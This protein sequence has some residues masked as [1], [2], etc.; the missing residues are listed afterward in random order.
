MSELTDPIFILGSHKSGSSLLRSLLDGHPDLYA[1]PTEAHFFQ[2]SG[3]WVD[4]RLRYAFPKEMNRQELIESFVS[5]IE[6]KNRHVNPYADSMLKGKFN[7]KL[8]KS[9]LEKAN[10]ESSAQLFEAYTSAIYLS[11]EGTSLPEGIRIVEKS[12][13]NAEFAIFLK[14]MMPSCRFIHIVRNPY[15]TLTA[16]RKSKAR[17][18]YPNLRDYLFLLQ[19]SHYYLFKNK[20]LIENYLVIRYED[21]LTEPQSTMKKVA[22]FLSISFSDNLLRPTVMSSQ[23]GGNSSE[24][25]PFERISEK[26]LNKW[27]SS[28]TDLEIQLVNDFLS[29][30]FDLYE[31]ERLEASKRKYWPIWGESGKNYLK[32]RSLLWLKPAVSEAP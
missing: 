2:N 11:L 18:Y 4:Y 28:I 31:Y 25:Q 13:E 8:F 16:I 23:W 32:N 14:Q 27:R 22:T 26:P 10:F 6:K 17:S 15:A 9:S 29:P 30:V 19:N 7:I 21:L 12:V 24:N 3:H 5:L 1:I 20:A